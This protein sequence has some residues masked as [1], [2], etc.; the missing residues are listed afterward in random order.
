MSRAIT[1]PG[2][3]RAM[4]Q[5][6]SMR[7]FAVVRLLAVLAF[8]AVICPIVNA[9]QPIISGTIKIEE[10]MAVINA[11]RVVNT[12]DTTVFRF[13]F[14]LNEL[15]DASG[16]P[17]T[18]IGDMLNVGRKEIR[19]RFGKNVGLLEFTEA[20]YRSRASI[21]TLRFAEHVTRLVILIGS[22]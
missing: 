13:R 2:T 15:K 16:Q 11:G 3:R 14:L 8:F 5:G 7:A 19:E 17:T 22:Q 1:R 4:M 20:A 18:E 6:D 10:Q 9:Q 12:D 21:K